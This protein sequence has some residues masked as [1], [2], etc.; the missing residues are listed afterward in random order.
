MDSRFIKQDKIDQKLRTLLFK[1]YY[2][3]I[4]EK[5]KGWVPYLRPDSYKSF[6]NKQF[7]SEKDGFAMIIILSKFTPGQSLFEAAKTMIRAYLLP[8]EIDTFCSDYCFAVKYH[9]II[10]CTRNL[11]SNYGL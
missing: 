6:Y 11:Q 5:N 8:E 4:E 10:C 9:R 1:N 2:N 7:N 3:N